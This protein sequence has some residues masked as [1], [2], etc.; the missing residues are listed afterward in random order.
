MKIFI[1]LLFCSS[2]FAWTIYGLDDRIE[3]DRH[4]DKTLRE[5]SYATA[6]LIHKKNLKKISENE[7]EVLG[8]TLQQQY[9]TCSEVRFNHQLSSSYCTGFLINESTLVSAG[10]CIKTMDDCKDYRWVFRYRQKNEFDERIFVEE[11][12][13]T[14]CN[15]I[16]NRD[17]NNRE[18]IDYA[19][20]KLN[21]KVILPRYFKL[22]R[23]LY[24]KPSTP[25]A[26]IGTPLGLPTKISSEAEVMKNT[27]WDS[28]FIVNTDT[29]EGSSG[30]PIVNLN[31]YQVEGI[32]V[33]GGD[34]LK[35][36]L[37]GCTE[38]VKQN[39][40]HSQ[41]LILKPRYIKF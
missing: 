17:G 3:A 21:K 26:A 34:D 40:K 31:D 2:S 15:Q 14:S 12:D 20:V 7:F 29:F 24:L 41:E 4:S 10:H 9:K 27:L 32:L 19:T 38:L 13:I 11:K 25:V 22:S 36:N 39:P 6:A 18:A 33:R 28:H 35:E 37:N 8:P 1:F 30:S 5:L 23:K 16:L